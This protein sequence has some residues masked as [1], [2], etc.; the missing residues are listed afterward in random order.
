MNRRKDEDI[1]L[2]F[3]PINLPDGIDLSDDPLPALRPRVYA[4]N[5]RECSPGL[6]IPTWRSNCGISARR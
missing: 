4:N 6:S 1:Y 3:D 5:R 2:A